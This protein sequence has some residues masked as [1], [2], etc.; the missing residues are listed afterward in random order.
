MNR[1]LIL[2]LAAGSLALP[3]AGAA[4]IRGQF[5]QLVPGARTSAEL[6]ELSPNS[7]A[8]LGAYRRMRYSAGPSV[9]FWWLRAVK[10]GVVDSELTP[11]FG[12]EIGNFSRTR[13]T[14][15]DS[16]AA[17]SLEMVF[18][19]D[20]AT[21]ERVEAITNPYTSERIPREDSLVGPTTIEYTLD[22]AKYPAAL[23]GAKFDVKPS[24]A[25]FA[26]EG[27]DVWL[28]D[29]NATTV[30]SADSG[31]RL[32]T[33]SDLATYHCTRAVLAD[34]TLDSVPADV[35]FNSVSSWIRWMNMGERPGS[36]LSRGSGRKFARLEDMP[37]PFLRIL[38]RRHP[39]LAQNPAAALDRP[40]F[41]FAP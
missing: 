28:R 17:T 6:S 14:G 30:T 32:F 25:A 15:P 29:D 4:E 21:G 33:V 5:T 31:A 12:M 7:R 3:D 40:P 11:I 37:E 23:P 26:V 8:L 18:F 36:M 20:L 35:S 16:F 22:G 9:T 39:E 41:S 24:I 34:A 2:R 27:E 13:T 38:R 1:R 19:T 10:Y